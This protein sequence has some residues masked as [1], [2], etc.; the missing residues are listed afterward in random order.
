MVWESHNDEVINIPPGFKITAFSESC[1][2]QAME[3]E[4][5]TRFGLQFHPE[6]D[7]SEY[8]EQIISN[9]VKVC[10]LAKNNP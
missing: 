4:N 7:H 3:N 8:G 6:V 1:Q 2:I 10:S 9:L 5:R